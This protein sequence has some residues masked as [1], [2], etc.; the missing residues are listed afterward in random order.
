MLWHCD[1]T[2]SQVCFN[3]CYKWLDYIALKLLSLPWVGITRGL[4]YNIITILNPRYHM[5]EILNILRYTLQYITSVHFSY[6]NEQQY[7]FHPQLKTFSLSYMK[8]LFAYIIQLKS[9]GNKTM[10]SYWLQYLMCYEMRMDS[11]RKLAGHKSLSNIYLCWFK[12]LDV[13]TFLTKTTFYRIT[14]EHTIITL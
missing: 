14:Y 12:Q 2:F 9:L 13:F 10:C 7:L 3:S 4:R 5:I 1:H 11:V 6:A 8:W